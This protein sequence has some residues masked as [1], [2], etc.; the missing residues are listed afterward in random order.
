MWLNILSSMKTVPEIIEALGGTGPIATR[1]G[2]KYQSRVAN[3]VHIG[4]P[5][6]QWPEILD[7]AKAKKVTLSLEELRAAE[8]KLLGKTVP[9]EDEEAA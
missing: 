8:A 4:I 6:Q 1:L 3:W 2:F 7:F 5:R 9:A